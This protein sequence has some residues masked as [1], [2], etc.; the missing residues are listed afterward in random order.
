MIGNGVKIGT[1]DFGAQT[2]VDINSAKVFEGVAFGVTKRFT[3][4]VSPSAFNIVVDP[5]AVISEKLVLLPISLKA[6]DAGPIYINIYFGTDC[7]SDGD[8][9]DCF[10]R[11]GESLNKCNLVVQTNPTI[12]DKGTKTPLEFVIHSNGTPAIATIGGEVI[13]DFITT[14][15]KDG[16]YLIEI[17]NQDNATADCWFGFN[18][19]EADK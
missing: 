7:D 16:K 14:L 10:N 17:L 18:F 19:F 13:D 2:T 4:P 3:A 5:T 12:N 1:F 8:D 6:F 9:I 15:R 11:D